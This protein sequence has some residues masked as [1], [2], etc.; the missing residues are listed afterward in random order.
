MRKW[1][2]TNS[3]A[4]QGL[5]IDEETGDNIAVSYKKEDAQLIAAAP[6]LLEACESAVDYL[7]GSPNPKLS[8]RLQQAINKAKGE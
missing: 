8:D 4:Y 1:Y 6:D 7:N 3:G 5:I 2:E